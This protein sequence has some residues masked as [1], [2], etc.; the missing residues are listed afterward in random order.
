M[1]RF[2][3]LL[4]VLV[5]ITGCAFVPQKVKIQP[6]VIVTPGPVP[7]GARVVIKV[8]DKRISPLI[9]YR[10]LDSEMATIKSEQ[11]LGELLQQEIVKIFR[12]RGFQIVNDSEDAT[13]LLRVDLKLLEYKTTMDFW[14]GGVHT[15][16]TLDAHGRSAGTFYEQSYTGERHANAQEAPGAK[17]NTGLIN[18]AVSDALQKLAD[19]LALARFLAN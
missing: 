12:Q 3:T 15:K 10:G 1:L 9:G 6:V 17:T 13:P 7:A 4:A 11:N 5:T 14:K 8:S 19:D 18:G 16:V 2:I